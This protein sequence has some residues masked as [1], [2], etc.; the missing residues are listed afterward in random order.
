MTKGVRPGEVYMERFW[1]PEFLDQEGKRD[2]SWRSVTV[3]RLSKSTG[4]LSDVNGTYTLRAYQ[5]AIAP[6]ESG[7]EG[8]W[9]E[10]EDFEPWMPQYSEPTEVIQTCV[11]L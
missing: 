4:R 1:L 8:A 7:P 9:T 2:Q 3:N 10:P 5:V 11:T 6:A